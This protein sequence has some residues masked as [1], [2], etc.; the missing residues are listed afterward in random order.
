MCSEACSRSFRISGCT[1][2]SNEQNKT[3]T[4]DLDV[5]NDENGSNSGSSEDSHENK[6][7]SG[8][9]EDSELPTTIHHETETEEDSTTDTTSEE[10]K[11]TDEDETTVENTTPEETTTESTTSTTTTTTHPTTTT[12]STTT[13]TTTPDWSQLCEA[14]CRNG[15][16][17]SFCNCD[18]PPFF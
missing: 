2:C 16:G 17:G 8:S 1:R 13:A 11:T 4:T 15:D 10:D 12:K 7:N 3:T 6:S 14:L 18:I 5:T 9:S